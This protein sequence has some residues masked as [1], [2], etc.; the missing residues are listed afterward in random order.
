ML[1]KPNIKTLGQGRADSI[2]VPAPQDAQ[3]TLSLYLP[4]FFA[5]TPNTAYKTII[6]MIQTIF[7]SSRGCVPACIHAAR[8][9]Y[10][11]GGVFKETLM[12]LIIEGAQIGHIVRQMVHIINE[13]LTKI[14][15]FNFYFYHFSNN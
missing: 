9:R 10:L 3:D 5:N 8:Q 7:F 14:S 15:I 11:S 13:P 6:S 4:N 12:K 1:K 2:P